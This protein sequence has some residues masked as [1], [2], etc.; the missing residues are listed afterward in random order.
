MASGG[1]TEF[2]APVVKVVA[3]AMELNKLAKEKTAL[4]EQLFAMEPVHVPD[5]KDPKTKDLRPR[6]QGEDIIRLWDELYDSKIQSIVLETVT[7]PS[8]P[9]HDHVDAFLLQDA[10]D[11]SLAVVANP[12]MPYQQL[13]ALVGDG[14][15]W[16]W[17]DIWK[18]LDY[19]PVVD[20]PIVIQMIPAI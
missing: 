6:A 11:A 7:G 2:D 10:G 13:R 5:V 9:N 12:V 18:Q 16:K 20:L 1:G 15:K 3:N 8:T 17:P 19:Y 4:L 14:G